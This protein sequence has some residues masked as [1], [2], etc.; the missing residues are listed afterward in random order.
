MQHL[1]ITLLCLCLVHLSSAAPGTSFETVVTANGPI[2]GHRAPKA[3]RV[4]EYLGIPYAEAP[5]G[6][7]RFAAP[8]AYTATGPQNASKFVST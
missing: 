6:E 3:A 7:L 1:L 4:W 5:V 8:R 2:T